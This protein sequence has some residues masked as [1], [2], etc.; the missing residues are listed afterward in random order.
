MAYDNED[1]PVLPATFADAL[2]ALEVNEKLRGEMSHELFEAFL[3]LKRD[4]LERFN[5]AVPEGLAGPVS[6][7]E[8]TEYF[9]HY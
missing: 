4:E 5:E 3:V 9:I 8:R 6:D 7:W 1:A 2:A